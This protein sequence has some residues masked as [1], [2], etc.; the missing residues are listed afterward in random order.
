MELKDKVKLKSG[1]KCPRCGEICFIELHYPSKAGLV[2]TSCQHVLK[3]NELV[4][5]KK[6]EKKS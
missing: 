3:K 2:L 4:Y 1:Y 6:K 5:V